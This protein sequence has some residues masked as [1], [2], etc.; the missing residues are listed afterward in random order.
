[1]ARRPIFSSGET[2]VNPVKVNE[3]EFNWFSGFSRSQCIKSIRS[4]HAEAKKMLSFENILEVSTCSENE[5]GIKLSAFNLRLE[6]DKKIITVEAAYQG[7]K[8]FEKGGPYHDI[9]EMD[10]YRAKTDER[11]KNSG[12]IIEFNFFDYHWSA[13]PKSAFYNW[14]YILSLSQ[15]KKLSDELEKFDAFSDIKFNPKNSLNCQAYSCALYVFL[16]RNNLLEK[17]LN[18]EGDYLSWI[19]KGYVPE[20]LLF[21]EK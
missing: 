12:K 1:M 4:L 16:K 15:N 14:I 2:E 5:L 7:S 3:I 21:E 11:I 13:E 17:V 18:R 8:V 19:G 9:Y 20:D 10:S 6:W